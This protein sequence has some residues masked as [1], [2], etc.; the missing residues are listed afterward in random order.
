MYGEAVRF[1]VSF[2]DRAFW[3]S[4]VRVT[5]TTAKRSASPNSHP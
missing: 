2:I 3:E 4:N 1:A 5:G